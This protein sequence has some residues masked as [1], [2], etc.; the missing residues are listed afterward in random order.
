MNYST[1][2]NHRIQHAR[3]EYSDDSLIFVLIKIHTK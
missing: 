2:I 1:L 3:S